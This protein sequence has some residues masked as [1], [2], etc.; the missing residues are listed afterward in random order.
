MLVYRGIRP[1]YFRGEVLNKD[2]PTR[3]PEDVGVPVGL[4][5]VEPFDGDAAKPDGPTPTPTS[6]EP[7][8]MG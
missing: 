8:G 1:E 5:G 3:V 7:A 6:D 2:T 4:F